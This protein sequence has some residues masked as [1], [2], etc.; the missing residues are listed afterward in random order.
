MQVITAVIVDDH[1]IVRAGLHSTLDLT[2]DIHVVT[3]AVSVANALRLTA[4]LQPDVLMLDVDLPDGNGI[5]V[6]R[7]LCAQDILTAI[8]IL[9]IH[10]DPQTINV[11]FP[12]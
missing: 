3:K 11:T 2:S 12:F 9:T 10:H 8:L 6:T 7:Q 1:P 5:D 4:K